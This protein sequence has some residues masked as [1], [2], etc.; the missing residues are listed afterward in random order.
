MDTD[1]CIMC[2]SHCNIPGAIYCSEECKIQDH[3]GCSYPT[4]PSST[5]PPLSPPA[6]YSSK[7][8]L[9]S[10]AWLMSKVQLPPQ[11]QTTLFYHR[12]PLPRY[13]KPGGSSKVYSN[14]R[15]LRARRMSKSLYVQ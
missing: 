13:Y 15:N 9:T 11:Q 10:S 5:S 4:S 8:I 1:W 6:L 2:N 7:P 3:L 14:P 12:A